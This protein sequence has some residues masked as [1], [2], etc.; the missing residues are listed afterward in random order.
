MEQESTWDLIPAVSKKTHETIL[1]FPTGQTCRCCQGRVA[2]FAVKIE[3]QQQQA[4]NGFLCSSHILAC[5]LD[6]L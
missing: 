4:K 1:E 5:P 2:A 3:K 6:F